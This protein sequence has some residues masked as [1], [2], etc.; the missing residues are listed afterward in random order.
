MNRGSQ[1]RLW[2]LHFHTPSSYDYKDKSV[3]NQQLIEG[4]KNAGMSVVAITDHHCIDIERIRELQTLGKAVGI[5]VLPGIEF[6]SELGGSEAIHFIGIFD[7]K[8]NLE[9]IWTKIQG[10]VLSHQ[11]KLMPKGLN[12]FIVHLF[13][14]RI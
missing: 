1:W 2:D 7:E 3:T 10:N 14:L 11:R 9:T 13:P 5:T 8:S 12:E 4:L 6:C